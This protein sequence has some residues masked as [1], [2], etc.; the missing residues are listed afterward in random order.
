MALT[1]TATFKAA[2]ARTDS[3]S[4]PR[5]AKKTRTPRTSTPAK[6][7]PGPAKSAPSSAPAG[8]KGKVTELAKPGS[9]PAKKQVASQTGAGKGVSN[10]PDL[11]AP[12]VI[13]KELKPHGALSRGNPRRILVVEFLVCFII[14]GAGTI[15]A[16]QGQGNG[17]PRLMSKG[18]A[19]AGLFLILALTSAGGEKSAR[20]AAGLGG[21]V[22]VA[23]IATSKDATNIAAWM[24]R[25]YGGSHPGQLQE[26]GQAPESPV[27]GA[28]TGAAT[29]GAEIG[30]GAAGLGQAAAEGGAALVGGL[31]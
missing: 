4:K 9:N 7:S 14:L 25:F 3:A 15:V 31:V 30:A 12:T 26:A 21:L 17:V 2:K 18:T 10:L 8:G 19:L 29:G 20:A 28:A 11:S 16:P 24:K 27:Q 5:P 1:D 13:R 23:Y 22:T 6:K